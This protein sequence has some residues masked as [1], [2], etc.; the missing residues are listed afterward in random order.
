MGGEKV[1]NVFCTLCFRGGLC[2]DGC[3]EIVVESAAEGVCG[4]A[5]LGRFEDGFWMD[6]FVDAAHFFSGFGDKALG[7]SV[8]GGH[9]FG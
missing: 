4:G 7:V 2:G 6:D 1:E 8:E 9:D 3:G 5:C